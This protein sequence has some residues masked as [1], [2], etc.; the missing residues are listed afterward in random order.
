MSMSNKPDASGL[1]KQERHDI[2]INYLKSIDKPTK[3]FHLRWRPGDLLNGQILRSTPM[4]WFMK[5]QWSRAQ[6]EEMFYKAKIEIDPTFD[7]A[8][9]QTFGGSPGPRWNTGG[10]II[11]TNKKWKQRH[12]QNVIKWKASKAINFKHKPLPS[13]PNTDNQQND[14]NKSSESHNIPTELTQNI[15][16]Y[17]NE[18]WNAISDFGADKS[19]NF[20]IF[21]DNLKDRG[22][23]ISPF[24]AKLLFGMFISS[25]NSSVHDRPQQKHF[26]IN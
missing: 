3:V 17:S 14:D 25:E 16:K 26:Q 19:I 6:I 1:T 7:Q 23:N 12:T 10:N 11:N 24:L 22:V 8:L 13:D 21:S 9:Q 20:E 15:G 18:I 5:Y 2:I 4:F